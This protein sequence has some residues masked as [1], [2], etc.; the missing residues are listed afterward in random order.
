MK[1]PIPLLK[2]SELEISV[3]V[4]ALGRAGPRFCFFK[5]ESSEIT[6][7][8][9]R[10]TLRRYKEE[11]NGQ[12]PNKNMLSPHWEMSESGS[13]HRGTAGQA[14]PRHVACWS[15]PL[16]MITWRSSWKIGIKK[17]HPVLPRPRSS[18]RVCMWEGP[19]MLLL[20]WEGMWWGRGPMY[21]SFKMRKKV[22]L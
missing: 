16:P 1:N 22:P 4:W 11:G 6:H 20:P 21:I 14:E 15:T 19:L 9:V 10:E 18:V 13:Y 2:P 8:N 12:G 5:Q 3:C 17:H 7:T